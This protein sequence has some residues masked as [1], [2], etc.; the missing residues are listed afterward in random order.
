MFL[1]AQLPDE[2][3]V[4]AELPTGQAVTVGR[5]KGSD[6]S[7][8]DV[9]ISHAHFRIAVNGRNGWIEDLDSRNGTYVNGSRI[10]D[11]TVSP[12]D[13]IQAGNCR[14]LLGYSP[15]EAHLLE[16]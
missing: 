1:I 8:P 13:L 11:A 14:I 10:S 4:E 12:G 5:G 6:I 9:A 2:S 16:N 7:I 15:A 3:T